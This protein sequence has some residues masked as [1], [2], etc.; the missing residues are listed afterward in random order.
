M[1]ATGK[2]VWPGEEDANWA[3]AVELRLALGLVPDDLADQALGEAHEAV[4]ETGRP[5]RELF[6]DP[7]SYARSLTRERLDEATRARVDL[8]GMTPGARLTSSLVTLGGI[9]IFLGC[10][11]W[12]A[13][14]PWLS[15]SWS[16]ITGFTT[17]ALVAVLVAIAVAAHTAGRLTGTRIAAAT[18][19]V[20]LAAG[21]TATRFLPRENVFAVPALALIVAGV[22]LLVGAVALPDSTINRWFTPDLRS[23]DDERWLSYLEGLL[24]GRHGMSAA[25]ARGH[26]GEARQHLAATSGDAEEA[27]GPADVYAMRLAES[28]GQER[29]RTRLKLYGVTAVAVLLALLFADKLRNPEPSSVWFWVYAAVVAYWIWYAA[30]AWSRA[31]ADRNR[32]GQHPAPGQR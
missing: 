27:F 15:A 17:V 10:G 20:V 11:Q 9:G 14:G 24:R 12:I 25:E 7:A 18:A 3:A 2:L 26:V 28:P 32:P 21:I 19:V 16:S 1:M 8:R 29:R 31:A 30:R 13:N 4:T 6:G 22:A 5:A 23:G